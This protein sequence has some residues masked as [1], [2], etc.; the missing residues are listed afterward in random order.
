MLHSSFT[1]E[2]SSRFQAVIYEES[3]GEVVWSCR[4]DDHHNELN[5]LTCAGREWHY[6]SHLKEIAWLPSSPE[7]A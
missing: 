1:A 5:A 2:S 3:T 7:Q 6:R 4:H